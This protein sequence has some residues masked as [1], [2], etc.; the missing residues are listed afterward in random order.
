MKFLVKTLCCS[1][2]V[3]SINIS[4]YS[5]TINI[6]SQTNNT[7]NA[8][9]NLYKEQITEFMSKNKA[10]RAQF[11]EDYKIDIIQKLRKYTDIIFSSYDKLL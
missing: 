1:L 8:E 2:L 5:S 10:E 3:F 4:A 9:E 7:I 6:A 11:T